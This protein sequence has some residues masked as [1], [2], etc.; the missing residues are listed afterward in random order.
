ME[1]SIRFVLLGTFTLRF[2]TGLTGS[3]LAFY[4]AHL[5][6]HGGP[7]VDATVVGL[8]AALFYLA[9]LILSPLFGILSDRYGHHRVM[10]YGPIFGAVAVVLTGFTPAFLVFGA[11]VMLLVL[12]A[13]R[14]LEGASSAA[15]VP[16]ILGYIAMAT[17]GNETLRGKTS[18]RFE[19][20]TVGL[21]VA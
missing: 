16:S 11:I 5:P 17:A 15:S 12:A 3:M 2:S 9:E 19:G 21:I 8:Y 7:T 1:R 13:T 14:I 18:A 4:L 6:D 20:A 10:L